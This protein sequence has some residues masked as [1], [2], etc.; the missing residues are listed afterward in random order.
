M[1]PKFLLSYFPLLVPILLLLLLLHTPHVRAINPPPTAPSTSS[2]HLAFSAPPCT[3]Y[4]VR[5][6]N[7]RGEPEPATFRV[8][9]KF[10]G[11]ASRLC[12][13]ENVQLMQSHARITLKEMGE[14][15]SAIFYE[16]TL[17]R[18]RCAL[19]VETSSLALVRNAVN[20][21][22]QQ[23]IVPEIC[24]RFAVEDDSVCVSV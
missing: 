22:M 16:P 11:Q 8:R 20:C 14:K 3:F 10:N 18:D 7:E 4:E 17:F 23:D 13:R 1:I 21:I 15:G 24:V 2:P 19:R 12:T 9:L 5:H 6:R